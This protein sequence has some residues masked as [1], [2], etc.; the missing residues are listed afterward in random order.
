ML[1]NVWLLS[2]SKSNNALTIHCVINFL[3]FINSGF[4]SQVFVSHKGFYENLEEQILSSSINMTLKII[5]QN[6]KIYDKQRVK[7]HEYVQ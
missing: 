2:I 5:N 3:N 6:V 4:V 1:I 7:T